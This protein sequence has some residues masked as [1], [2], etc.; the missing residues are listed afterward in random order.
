MQ[1]PYFDLVAKLEEKYEGLLEEQKKW[2]MMLQE[3]QVVI[4]RIENHIQVCH[5]CAHLL[6]LHKVLYLLKGTHLVASRHLT[7]TKTLVLSSNL[8]SAT[9]SRI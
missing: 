4:D 6:L 3:R 5:M 7:G 2:N 9:I 1:V 8:H